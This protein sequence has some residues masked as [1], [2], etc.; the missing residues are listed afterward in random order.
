[1]GRVAE[2]ARFTIQR[3]FMCHGYYGRSHGDSLLN[4]QM[5]GAMSRTNTFGPPAHRVGMVER[6]EDVY[7]NT[8]G[9]LVTR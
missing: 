5:F 4:P 2:G 7:A 6:M 1:M 8:N 9:V 3:H